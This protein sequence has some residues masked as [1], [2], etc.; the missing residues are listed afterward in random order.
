MSL[1]YNSYTNDDDAVADFLRQPSTPSTDDCFASYHEFY[2][3]DGSN[4]LFYFGFFVDTKVRELIKEV[5][6]NFRNIEVIEV[7][8]KE[9]EVDAELYYSDNFNSSPYNF[10]LFRIKLSDEYSRE[11]KFMLTLTIA[12]FIRAF[13]PMYSHYKYMKP[14]TENFIDNTLM[15]FGLSK[16]SYGGWMCCDR[17]Q[18]YTCARETF[19]SLDSIELVNQSTNNADL[20]YMPQITRFIKVLEGSQPPEFIRIW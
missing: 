20:Q 5:N 18:K 17:E 9:F 4:A 10:S 12:E 19:N 2:P 7:A 8:S 11:S 1:F 16:F 6:E 13:S 15:G 14:T 3:S